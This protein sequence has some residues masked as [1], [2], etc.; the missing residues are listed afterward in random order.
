MTISIRFYTVVVRVKTIARKYPGGLDAY[1]RDNQVG[2]AYR[3]EHI[4]G[5]LFMNLNDVEAFIDKLIGLGFTYI[6]NKAYDEIA[7]VDMHAGPLW[8]CSWL[9]TSVPTPINRVKQPIC[10][11]KASK[12][13]RPDGE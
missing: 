5:V 7:L 13:Q 11:F 4:V 6:V 2:K 12:A 9:E 8:P 3:D 10:R 1:I